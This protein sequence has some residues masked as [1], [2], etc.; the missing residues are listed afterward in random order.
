[1]VWNVFLFSPLLG[2]MIQFDKYF[3]DVLKPPTRKAFLFARNDIITFR[4]GS[5]ANPFWMK[6]G[7]YRCLLLVKGNLV[8]QLRL[9]G[10][11]LFVCLFV[12]FCFWVVLSDEQTSNGYPQGGGWAPTSLVLTMIYCRI[13]Y[14]LFYICTRRYANC[15]GGY[16]RAVMDVRWYIILY[17]FIHVK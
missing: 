9:V 2:E 12:C 14:V 8:K 3:S 6:S 16:Q 13:R 5:L 17:Y 11:C 4:S 15:I 7:P 1:M 10:A